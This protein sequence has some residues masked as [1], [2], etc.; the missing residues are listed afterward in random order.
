[1]VTMIFIIVNLLI[2]FGVGWMMQFFH[3]KRIETQGRRFMVVAVKGHYKG[4]SPIPSSSSVQEVSQIKNLFLDDKGGI[5]TLGVFPTK[6]KAYDFMDIVQKQ[7]QDEDDKTIEVLMVL[8]VG[9]VARIKK[10]ASHKTLRD[11]CV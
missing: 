2:L 8:D 7:Q 9:E 3:K 4:F 1:M 10:Q 6:E 11:F 5:R